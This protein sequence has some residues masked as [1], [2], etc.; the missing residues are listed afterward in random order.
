MASIGMS[1][2]YGWLCVLNEGK[3]LAWSLCRLQRQERQTHVSRAAARP[4]SQ[5]NAYALPRYRQSVTSLL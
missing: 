1:S 3:A 2:Q 4:R 5:C